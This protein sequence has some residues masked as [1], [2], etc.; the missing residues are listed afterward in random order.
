MSREDNNPKP[1][2]LT[3]GILKVPLKTVQQN[4]SWL[5]LVEDPRHVL[6]PLLR[7]LV[8]HDLADESQI[9]HQLQI[10]LQ[11]LGASCQSTHGVVVLPGTE[12][13]IMRVMMIPIHSGKDSDQKESV[14]ID[15]LGNIKG[16]LENS[17]SRIW[18]DPGA[19]YRLFT[20]AS[21]D[22]GLAA[23]I[24]LN[25]SPIGALALLQGE[26]KDKERDA[27]RESHLKALEHI[28]TL[29][30]ELFRWLRHPKEAPQ[31]RY[32]A[33]FLARL[34]R[35]R[36]IDLDSS[37]LNQELLESIDESLIRRTR[38]L[39]LAREGEHLTVAMT[40]PL[41][42][43]A[44]QE[45]ELGTQTNIGTRFIITD[46]DFDSVLGPE[47]VLEEDDVPDVR[48]SVLLELSEQE[49]GGSE[50]LEFVDEFSAPIIRLANLLIY[51]AFK[52]GASDIHIEP[53]EEFVVIRYRI[54]G[55]C[56]EQDKL[57]NRV[58][59]PLVNRL[60]IMASMNIAERR[61]P[62]DGRIKFAHFQRDVDVDLRVSIIPTVYGE[63]VVMR[64]L[65]QT[66]AMIPLAMLGFSEDALERYSLLTAAQYGMLLHCGPT[67]S[68]KSMSMFSALQTLN[69]PDVKILTAENPV[70]YTLKGIVQVE[71]NESVGLTFATCLRAFLRQDPDIILIGEMRDQETANI[72]VQAAL[73]GH[74]LF[75]TL[76][77]NDACSTITRLADLGVDPFLIGD[78]TLGICAQR[79]VRRLCRCKSLE[80][81]IPAE[82]DLFEETL[83]RKLETLARPNGCDRCLGKGYKGRVGVYELLS[84]NVDLRVAINK[85]I[86]GDE[87]KVIARRHG[88]KTLFEEGLL[89]VEEQVISFETLKRQL[90]M[91]G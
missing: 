37:Q 46:D 89:K 44:V 86:F 88:M 48:A 17:Q 74:K 14:K 87:L 84:M 54:D 50:S 60:K 34:T 26:L 25:G 15:E 70:E 65:Q 77:T 55:L 58:H 78:A 30:A 43:E 7:L 27:F 16:V 1:R 31:A 9:H 21:L 11:R 57:P 19:G 73:T 72:G 85:R 33:R 91:D 39:P 80:A 64:L 38:I 76:H 18:K 20:N 28:A 67:G 10:C 82:R 24:I 35:C 3:S 36:S 53:S 42:F 63:S 40:N 56:Q 81:P 90:P 79:L 8:Q 23:P 59:S 22:S 75:S 61:V 52:L 29:A 71:T 12:E 41:S 5:D 68:G 49:Q 47:S 4:F 2:G 6:D 69:S 45:F 32:R 66:G 51:E 62:Q 83:A 13:G